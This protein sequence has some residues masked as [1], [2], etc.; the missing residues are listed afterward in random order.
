MT[1][2]SILERNAL[3][4]RVSELHAFPRS[5]YVA[6]KVVRKVDRYVEDAL[7]EVGILDLLGQFVSGGAARVSK[8]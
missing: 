7:V 1:H 8:A 6:V 3:F 4:L 2:V 5:E